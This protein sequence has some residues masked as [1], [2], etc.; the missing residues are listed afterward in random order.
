MRPTDTLRSNLVAS[1]T[2]TCE[3]S[4]ANINIRQR[5][6]IVP[7][8]KP[9]FNHDIRHVPSSVRPDV[10]EHYLL[11]VDDVTLLVANQLPW[12]SSLGYLPGEERRHLG[13]LQLRFQPAVV[14]TW[15]WSCPWNDRVSDSL[16]PVVCIQVDDLMA[17]GWVE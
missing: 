7:S 12:I 9:I 2:L 8:C 14:G 1:C 13:V 3:L 6:L 17:V 5:V 11:C 10:G 16:L 4:S 15:D